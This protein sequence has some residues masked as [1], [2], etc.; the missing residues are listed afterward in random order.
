MFKINF[1]I[2][3]FVIQAVLTFLIHFIMIVNAPYGD[4]EIGM[5]S[6]ALILTVPVQLLISSVLYLIFKNKIKYF[7]YLLLSWLILE[8]AIILLTHNIPLLTMFEPGLRGYVS[9]TYE[10]PSL[11]ATGLS[12]FSYWLYKWLRKRTGLNLKS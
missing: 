9:S 10:I 12:I 1:M 8:L 11:I 6:L 3:F 7:I 4:G 2:I 5:I